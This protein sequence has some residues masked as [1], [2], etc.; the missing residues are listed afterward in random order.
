MR[1]PLASDGPPPSPDRGG[2]PVR[3]RARARRPHRRRLALA[4]PAALTVLACGCGAAR[5][6]TTAAP[7]GSAATASIGAGLTGPATLRASVYAHGPANAAAFALD[8]HGRLWITSA[9]LST[10][11]HDGVYLVASPGAR[12]VK[13]IGGLEDPIGIVWLRG[14]LYVASVGRVDAYS[15]FDGALFATHRRVLAG[16]LAGAENNTLAVAPDGRL[17]MG[18]SATCD[19]CT[20][21]SRWSGSIVSFRADGSDLRLYA[22][23]IRAPVGLAFLPGSARLIVSMNQRDDLGAAT[24]GDWLAEVAESENWRFPDCYAVGTSAC[25]GVPRPLA[26]LDPHAAVGPVAIVTGQLGA[27]VGTAAIVAEWST[28]R[29]RSVALNASAA[30][31]AGHVGTLL[32]GMHNPLA[33]I[34]AANGSLLVGD[35][36]SGTI[37][38][39]AAR[40]ASVPAA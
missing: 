33:L 31:A 26:E 4:L 39:I 12:A 35:W 3:S 16:P 24:P 30:R 17:V 14:V 37:Y 29:V 15:G 13:V 28:G 21:A 40:P 32:A 2:P 27:E 11:A 10:H 1:V 22:E 8:A 19:H 23:R 36:S 34:V 20:P 9:G 18:V 6:T 7:H 25:S 5:T 38:R